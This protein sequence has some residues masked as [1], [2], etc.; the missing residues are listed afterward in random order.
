MAPGGESRPTIQRKEMLYVKLNNIHEVHKFLEAVNQAKRV[1]W[2]ESTE[3][4]KLNLKSQLSQYV[5]IG[6]LLSSHGVDYEL[7]C[8]SKDDEPLFLEFFQENP[9][10]L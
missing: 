3:G 4:D 7:F 9:D 8:A 2:L 1:V 5:A 10:T 6:A